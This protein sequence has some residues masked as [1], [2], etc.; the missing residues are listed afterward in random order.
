[1]YSQIKIAFAN[2]FLFVLKEKL[3]NSYQFSFKKLILNIK[4]KYLKL[5]KK[6]ISAF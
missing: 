6:E 5:K 2:K 3:F 4:Y 1:M